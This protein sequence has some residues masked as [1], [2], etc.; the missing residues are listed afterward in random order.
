M[1]LGA[2]SK[3][4]YRGHATTAQLWSI[5]SQNLPRQELSEHRQQ[6]FLRPAHPKPENP[7]SFVL[8]PPLF[9]Q[10]ELEIQREF[11]PL[12]QRSLSKPCSRS[13]W[14]AI[15]CVRRR[16]CASAQLQQD[17]R[18]YQS[19]AGQSGD[20]YLPNRQIL[21]RSHKDH[22]QALRFVCAVTAASHHVLAVSFPPA[23]FDQC[24]ET[25]QRLFRKVA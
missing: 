21:Q 11:P 13:G 10:F 7:I 2:H 14:L 5:P 4:Q 9:C 8:P 22:R 19:R 6:T 12:V 15:P 17:W 23:R 3:Y 1:A 18:F 16:L 25:Y 20:G 24:C